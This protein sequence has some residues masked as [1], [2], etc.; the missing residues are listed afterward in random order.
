MLA[1]NESV[2]P[3][4]IGFMAPIEPIP[5]L[6]Y[7]G[8]PWWLGLLIEP[9]RETVA[10]DR[11]ERLNVHP[12]L[13]RFSKVV[14]RRAG[15]SQRRYYAVI[16][17]LLFVPEEYVMNLRDRDRALKWAHV[18]GFVQG[19]GG[20]ARIAKGGKHGIERIREMEAA[21]NL[22]ETDIPAGNGKALKIGS[23]VSLHGVWSWLGD[24]VVVEVVSQGRIGVEVSQL[25]GARRK[26][27]VTASEIEVM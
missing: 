11:L 24:G 6:D 18:R 25:F 27:Y 16:S 15:K 4:P 8:F 7:S 22:P 5:D 13:P 9:N 1:I 2:K 26:V 19:A 3:Q 12:Y 17:G 21:L 20:I 23:E 10:A 14:R